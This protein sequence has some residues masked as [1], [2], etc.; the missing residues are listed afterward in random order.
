MKRKPAMQDAA[1]EAML[2]QDDRFEN[3]LLTSCGRGGWTIYRKGI[4]RPDETLITGRKTG[5]GC[6]EVLE[7]AIERGIPA[8]D[9]RA[10][11]DDKITKYSFQ[12][13]ILAQHPSQVEEFEEASF[14]IRKVSP[15]KFVEFAKEWGAAVYN[16]E[17]VPEW[18]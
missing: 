1:D 7:E 12:S 16:E 18:G 13:P 17:N 15:R 3:A 9:T 8:I 11:P 14:N 2:R 5:F 10:I 4:L 6:E